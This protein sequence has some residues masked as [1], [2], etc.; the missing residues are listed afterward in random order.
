MIEPERAIRDI[1]AQDYR[2]A[3]YRKMMRE[4]AIKVFK[5]PAGGLAKRPADWATL[6]PED[7]L[8]KRLL[9]A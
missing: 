5:L 8:T 2:P 6:L 7:K 9:P 3:S 1:D 4:N